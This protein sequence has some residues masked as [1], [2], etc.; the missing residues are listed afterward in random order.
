LKMSG[1]PGKKQR[2]C[3]L[4]NKK[5]TAKRKSSGGRGKKGMKSGE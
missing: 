4:S 2:I 3:P 1:Y 5:N